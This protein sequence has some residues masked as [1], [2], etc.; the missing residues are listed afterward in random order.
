MVQP[1]WLRWPSD[2]DTIKT[3]IPERLTRDT[4]AAINLSG[5]E[6]DASSLS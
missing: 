6:P 5:G 4:T 3:R 2:L 1:G